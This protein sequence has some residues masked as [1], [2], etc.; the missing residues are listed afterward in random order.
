MATL[1]GR[2]R[3]KAGSHKP[4]FTEKPTWV[5]LNN[6]QIEELIVKLAK[7]GNTSAKIGLILRDSYGINNI[8]GI[9]G[10]K[11]EKVLEE[12]K[13]EYEPHELIAVEKKHKKLKKHF[14][15]NKQD[16]V[17]KRGLQ[18]TEVKLIRL[19]RYHK[20]NK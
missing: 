16:K 13:I 3:G 7:E 10:K 8:R 4:I 17:A 19:K 14:E 9:I 11:I 18:L 2:G 5:V 20:R 12:N 15:S 6:K 1:Y